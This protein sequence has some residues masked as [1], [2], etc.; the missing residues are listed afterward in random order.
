MREK[1]VQPVNK[2]ASEEAR[3]L[4]DYLYSVAGKGIITGQHTQTNG[5]EEIAYIRE[6][7]GAEPRLTGFELLAYSPNINYKDASK[8]CLTEVYENRGTV[9]TALRWAK[10]TGGIVTLSFHWFSPLGGHDKSFYAKNTEF[11]A[12]RVLQEGT[13]EKK[14]FYH[15]MDVIAIQLK[16]FQE[17]GIPVLWRPFH[18]ADGTWFWWGAKGA[19]VAKELYLLMF[20]HYTQ[21]HKLN[22][23]LWVWNCRLPEGY[24]GD[25]FVD[26]ISVDVYL[27]EYQASDYAKEYRELIE[28]TGSH[29][30]AA[31]AEVGYLPDLNLLMG[32]HIP[33]AYYMAWSKEFCMGE[34]YNRVEKLKELYTCDYAVKL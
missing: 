26:V 24:P 20:A 6:H 29:K 11:D 10:E 34:Q 21:V 4:L 17:A 15:D 12:S 33:W 23:L 14:A 19:A 1:K 25:D 18:E 13:A 2:E 16:R 32:S 3:E 7:T 8:E 30:V 28:A 27:P 31:L 22:N 9:D 5:M